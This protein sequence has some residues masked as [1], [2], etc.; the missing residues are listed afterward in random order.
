ME[1]NMIPVT[2]QKHRLGRLK[3]IPR[4]WLS[5]AHDRLGIFALALI[6]LGLVLLLIPVGALQGVGGI[7]FG[8]GLT[9]LI[10]M[11]SN[12]Q[13]L[14]KDANLRRKTEVYG[15]LHAELQTLRERL[16]ETRA[17]SQSYLQWID[18]KGM[19]PDRAPRVLNE[20]PLRLYCWP[21]FKADFRNL[22]FSEPTRQL[23]N[24]TQQLAT[25]YN[26]AVEQALVASEAA[27]APCIKTAITRVTQSEEFQQWNQDSANVFIRRTMG[28]SSPMPNDWF[29]RIRDAVTTPAPSPTEVAWATWWLR[30]AP[31]GY[32]SPTTLGWLLAG[33][34]DQAVHAIYSVLSS[35]SGSYPT[36][37][38]EWL[39]TIVDEAWPTLESHPTYLT[40][41]TLHEELFRQVS[42]TE[43][44]LVDK[45]R[46]IQDTY[47][48][49]PPPL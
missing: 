31:V 15:P 11:W 29:I 42:Q 6:V 44:K 30:A 17:G 35:P 7:V 40:V 8:T 37:P 36:P 1:T 39:H 32:Y 38:F 16:E 4:R 26:I 12:R 2:R 48:G 33:N 43:T 5:F 20:E 41:Q 23:L 34:H 45:L 27:F 13:Q 18:V 49:G 28:A 25:D 10:S 9:V 46:Y 22:D 14:A 3:Q 21:E 19:E 24:K 47:E